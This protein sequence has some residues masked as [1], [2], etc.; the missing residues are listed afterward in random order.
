MKDIRYIMEAKAVEGLG[1]GNQTYGKITSTKTGRSM[2]I[3]TPHS[4]NL[5][6]AISKVIE[7]LYNL[8]LYCGG[9]HLLCIDTHFYNARKWKKQRGYDITAETIEDSELTA[10]VL[11]TLDKEV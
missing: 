7:E 11:A 6:S 2:Y 9:Q 8:P 5:R 1:C 3:R 4:S 10:Q